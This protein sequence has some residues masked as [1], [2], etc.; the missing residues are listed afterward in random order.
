MTEP[1]PLDLYPQPTTLRIGVVEVRVFHASRYLDV[2]FPDQTQ[3]AATP[4]TTDHDREVAAAVGL[5]DMW[6]ATVYHELCHCIID[7]TFHPAKS[8]LRGT[9]LKRAG[10]GDYA[11]F[12]KAEERLVFS[13]T[14]YAVSGRWKHWLDIFGGFNTGEYLDVLGWKLGGRVKVDELAEELRGRVK[15]AGL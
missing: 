4:G 3:A 10:L 2:T 1:I 12:W 14:S 11:E 6:T 7:R 13:L 15:E 8:V 5:T 9:A